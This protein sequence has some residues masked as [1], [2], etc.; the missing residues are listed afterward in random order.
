M[1]DNEDRLIELEQLVQRATEKFEIE[2]KA[3]GFDPAQAANVALPG[4][5]AQLYL[6]RESLV[7]QLE[8]LK[9]GS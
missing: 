1:I 2:M 3:R 7:Q 8:E 9:R 6:E 4:R 5:L